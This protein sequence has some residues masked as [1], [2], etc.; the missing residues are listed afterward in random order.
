MYKF[1]RGQ[2]SYRPSHHKGGASQKA[3][4]PAILISS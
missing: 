1:D 4:W 3:E 2:R